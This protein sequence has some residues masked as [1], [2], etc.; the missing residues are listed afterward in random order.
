MYKL[1]LEEQQFWIPESFSTFR[2]AFM[3]GLIW[4]LRFSVWQRD[5]YG[6][7]ELLGVCDGSGVTWRDAKEA[8]EKVKSSIC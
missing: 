5:E 7:Y 8:A 4:E 1:L 3:A 2:D 6:A